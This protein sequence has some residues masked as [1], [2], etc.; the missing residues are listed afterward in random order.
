M[1]PVVL[2]VIFF[3]PQSN[4]SRGLGLAPNIIRFSSLLLFFNYQNNVEENQIVLFNKKITVPIIYKSTKRHETKS[5][6][7]TTNR[8]FAEWGK[9]FDSTTVATAI[10]D[11]LVSNSEILI[12]EGESYRKKVHNKLNKNK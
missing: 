7:I 2:F 9:L 4:K 6:I 11:R 3:E 12:L 1:V 5:T 8:P 10:A